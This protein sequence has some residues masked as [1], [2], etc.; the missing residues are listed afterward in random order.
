MIKDKLTIVIPAK[1]E[2]DVI[3]FT[4]S[5]LNTQY[6]IKGTRVIVADCSDDMTVNIV[7]SGKYKNLHLEVIDG[8]L[9]SV[10][11]NNGAKLAK[12]DY[13]LFLDADIFLTD[14]NTIYETLRSI[15]NN[16]FHLVTTKFRVKGFYFFI[17]P[18][19]EF[20]RNLIA[21][22]APCA[23]GGYMLFKLSEFNKVGGFVNEDK[24]GEDFHLSMK[25]NP[26]RFSVAPHK[27][28]TTDRRFRNK[29]LW[30]MMKMAFL[31]YINRNNDNFFKD[32]HNYWKI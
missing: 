15:K 31:G 20:F 10:A 29:G 27:I 21:S 19:F 13:V 5:L 4:L 24:F 3:G 8:G 11:R 14:R 28:Y 18:V 16:R 32:D 9:P 2:A 1:N 6:G 23:I 12:T 17:F 26:R 30:Y 7:L 25:I 22:K